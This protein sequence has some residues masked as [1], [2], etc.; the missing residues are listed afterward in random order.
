MLFYDGKRVQKEK[1][2]LSPVSEPDFPDLSAIIDAM[3]EYT[4]TPGTEL[5]IPDEPA[6]AEIHPSR[7]LRSRWN[8]LP[9]S[10]RTGITVGLLVILLSHVFALVVLR[11][12]IPFFPQ[13]SRLLQVVILSNLALVTLCAVLLILLSWQRLR[14]GWKIFILYGGSVFV[15][16]QVAVVALLVGLSVARILIH[17][18]DTGNGYIVL[19]PN[20]TFTPGTTPNV[21]TGK[22]GV[23]TFII[24]GIHGKEDTNTDTLMVGM[25][26]TE[27]KKCSILSIPRDTYSGG[28]KVERSLKKINGAYSYGVEQMKYEVSTIIGYE[29]SYVIM[30]DYKA[31]ERLIDAI[32]GLYFE[33]P[34]DMFVAGDG[35]DLK[36]GEGLNPPLT[37]KKA[38]MLVRFRVNRYYGSSG[39]YYGT[40]Y[41][42][43][44]RMAMQQQVIAAAA[45]QAMANWTKVPEYITI[46][47][48]NIEFDDL[49]WGEL[50][51]LAECLKE[52][53]AE[54]INFFTLPT[55]TVANPAEF[56]GRLYYY[57]C[58]K[59]DE[60]LE[61]IDENLN[62]F[63]D[64]IT[65]NM[66]IYTQ[67]H[68]SK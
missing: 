52:I 3:D 6:S 22:G 44:G 58:V 30:V 67:L 31:F 5:S 43:Y 21:I 18:P 17:L 61:W 40:G 7:G 16:L 47:T 12:G 46:A 56:G 25:L 9:H 27:T 33:V 68:E 49:G 42:D 51:G 19:P 24:A 48:E 66:V 37:G 28:N 62:P 14:K 41:D 65:K 36:K 34:F 35:I 23:Y 1:L 8:G 64:P 60:A 45:K 53:G 38:L 20:G 39:M 4:A 59:A 11:K 54:N 63:H 26:D 15:W 13:Y 2:G 29:P 32:G 55:Y 50:L 57:E 10:L